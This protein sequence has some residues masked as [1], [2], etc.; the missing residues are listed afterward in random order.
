MS[1]QEMERVWIAAGMPQL[2]GM[3][4]YPTNWAISADRVPLMGVP[5]RIKG[6]YGR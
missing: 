6:V 5:A 4:G 1:K 3:G 2:I